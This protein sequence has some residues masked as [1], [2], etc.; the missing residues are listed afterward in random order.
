MRRHT[1]AY[2]AL[3]ALLAIPAAVPAAEDAADRA[4]TFTEHVAPIFMESC[5]ECHRPNELAPMSLLSYEEARPW[6]KSIRRAVAQREMPP[7]DAVPGPVAFA[8][9]ISLSDEEIRTIVA[10]VDQGAPEGDPAK[11]PPV[12]EFAEGWRLGEPDLVVELPPLEVPA[13]GEDLFPTVILKLDSEQARNL[14]GIEWQVDNKQVMHH[15]VLFEGM[16]N[17][18]DD[19]RD[20]RPEDQRRPN[21]LETPKLLYVW[22]AGSPPGVFP[23]GIGRTIGADATLTFNLHYH[24][25]GEAA[26]DASKLGLY[27]T[28]EAP[29]KTLVTATTVNPSLHLPAGSDDYTLETVHLFTQDV[30]LVSLLPHMHQRGTAVSYKLRYP[31]GRA[32]TI[33]DVPEYDFNW[34]WIYYLEEPLLVPA[35]TWLEVVGRWDNTEANPNNPDPTVDVLWGDGSNY[36]MLAGIFDFVAAEGAEPK[37]EP[38]MKAVRG[39]LT[40]HDPADSYALSMGFMA[41]G[42]H[43]PREGVGMMYLPQNTATLS[44]HLP[45][46]LWDGDRFIANTYLL[47]GAADSFPISVAASIGDDGTMSGELYFGRH[48]DFGALPELEGKGQKFSGRRI[49][50]DAVASAG[51]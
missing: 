45:D 44:T 43:L 46:V 5:A 48:L 22:A 4:V 7:W 27:F 47:R 12:P 16:V 49:E 50:P 41:F 13:D 33:L 51:R 30:K 32:E 19:I 28:D 8:N 31:D 24:P 14:R 6:A 21:P 42:L 37:P 35:G 23:D 11:M 1:T 9:D 10:W 2:L 34:Q 18:S 29:E 40:R 25:W 17:M 15:L 26:T 20:L 39:Y 3:I 36:E 38:A